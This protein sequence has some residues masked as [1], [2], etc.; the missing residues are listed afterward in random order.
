[1]N[2]SGKELV[3]VN[4]VS[5][6][7]ITP[8]VIEPSVGVDR[9]FYAI[10]CDKYS[11]EKVD[12]EEREVLHLPFE[13][14]PYKFAVLPLSNKLEDESKKI[15]DKIIEKG[16]SC[17]FDVSGSIGKRYRRQDAIGTPYCITYDFS[18]NETNT[19]TVRERD[20]MKQ[21]KINISKLDDYLIKKIYK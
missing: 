2:E 17:I 21:E 20:S 9:L 8:I 14:A 1:M 7:K 15:Y 19:V 18:S 6:E 13:L 16:V 4:P 3:Y 12:N 5:G 10:V 11:V